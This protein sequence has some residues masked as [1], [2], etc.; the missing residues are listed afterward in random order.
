MRRGYGT[1]GCDDRVRGRGDGITTWVPL[2]PVDGISPND[3][4]GVGCGCWKGSRRW[5]TLLD[6]Y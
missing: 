4:G 1:I 5:S 6:L 3:V 2:D